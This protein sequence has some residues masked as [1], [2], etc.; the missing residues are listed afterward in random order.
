MEQVSGDHS[1]VE[2]RIVSVLFADLVGFTSLSERLDAEDVGTIQDAYFA[3]VTDTVGRYG[4]QLEKFIGDAA[5]AVFGLPITRDDDAERAVRAG[6]ALVHAVEGLAG[7]IGLDTGD[8]RIRVGVNTGEVV[9]SQVLPGPNE[10]ADGR[11][12]GD[13]VNTAARLQT[14]APPGR[15]LLGEATALAVAE[16]IEL[17]PAEAIELKG[18]AAPVRASLALAVRPVRSRELAMG[19]LRARLIGRNDSLD[20]L[21]GVL[22]GALGGGAERLLVVAP[23]GVGKTRLVEEFLADRPHIHVLRA[24]LRPDASSPFDPVAQLLSWALDAN[25]SFA[26]Q[27]PELLERLRQ[28][29]ITAARARVVADDVS[30][31][32]A[33]E[34][35]SP[36]APA[37]RD[38]LFDGWATMLDAIAP[39]RGS[40]WFLEDLH[41]ADPDLLDFLGAAHGRSRAHG[42]LI[43]ATARPAIL[44]RLPAGA[45]NGTRR[46]WPVL[47]LETLDV[48]AASGLVEA[49]IGPVLPA[50]L[51]ARI[52]ERSDG[53]PLFI[54]ELLR[55]W[56]SVG[57]LAPPKVDLARGGRPGWRLTV[58]AEEVPLPI[59]VQAIY[60]AQLDDLPAEA[61]S[62]ARRAAIAGRRFPV[63][64]L[65]ALNVPDGRASLA[66]LEGRALIAGPLP[67]PI[68]G[69]EYS[70]RHALLRDAGYASLSRAERARLHVRFAGWLE[71]T[72]GDRVAE[73]AE[74]IGGHFEAALDSTP[75]LAAEVG[76]GLDRPA[77][78]RLAAGWLE[79]AAGLARLRFANETARSLFARS[80]ALSPADGGL[81]LARRLAG[82]AEATARAADL[83]TAAATFGRAAS[84]YRA[85]L[86]DEGVSLE[87]RNLARRGLG[88]AA[89]AEADIRYEQLRFDET[90]SIAEAALALTG[91]DDPVA[92]VPLLIARINGLEGLSNDYPALHLTAQEVVAV[93]RRSADPDLVF[94]AR[95]VALGIGH[96]AGVTTADD[97][98]TFASEARLLGRWEA[99]IGAMVNA[100]SLMG[101]AD[102]TR[103]RSLANE[104]Q[105]IA[106]VRGLAERLA[107]I[108][109]ARC[110]LELEAGDWPLA[111]AEAIR[112]LDLAEERG[113]DRAAVRTWFAIMPIADACADTDLLRRAATWFQERRQAFPS[114]PYGTLNRTAIEL[115]LASAGLGPS[116]DLDPALL[117]DGFEQ[118]ENAAGWL[119]SIERIVDGWLAEGRLEVAAEGIRR[120]AAVALPDVSP[121]LAASRALVQGR[122]TKHRA[123]PGEATAAARAALAAARTAGAPWWISQS[124][125]LLDELGSGS[126][127]EHEEAIGIER[128]L[129]IAT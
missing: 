35:G 12:T 66:I 10:P 100:T 53:N 121:L 116:P 104:A 90:T 124:L 112:A 78:A 48:G 128:T 120:Y 54:E 30:Q 42:R 38:A 97:W 5:M 102:R 23:P 86:V 19:R 88:A 119:A 109:Q 108:G 32:A 50:Q 118:V 11:V 6:L 14:A 22:S 46:S 8:L 44:E 36:P 73:V 31:L 45:S 52:V 2:R 80:V 4:G 27:R 17:E 41:W 129:G 92:S 51:V 115:R 33:P 59:S 16:S 39:D 62:A 37:D 81:D 83:D 95:R 84:H 98:L 75:A 49:L 96:A 71:R 82:L 18:K 77:T 29:G 126:A 15:V 40:V 13:T 28:A 64:A 111:R 74:A 58:P 122:L 99:A 24:R 57:T 105:T 60:A 101:V 9:A 87:D 72:A 47:D 20:R 93:A 55:T 94:D 67:N 61:R 7:R 103:V 89:A 85:A 34:A 21:A 107:W 70:Y 76:E 63:A 114:S 56:V 79:R 125:R 65:E 127:T 123:Q 69:D 1:R 25:R 43:L 113:Y 3:T 110:E 26:A 68:T 117:L 91:R 106:Q